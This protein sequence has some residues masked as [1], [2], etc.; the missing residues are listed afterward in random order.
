MEE[1]EEEKEEEEDAEVIASRYGNGNRNP[2]NTYCLI[3]RCWI[4]LS[5]EG[6][7][8]ITTPS[9][10]GEEGSAAE[11]KAKKQ[12]R[13]VM[14]RVLMSVRKSTLSRTYIWCVKKHKPGE[15]KWHI[16][17]YSLHTAHTTNPQYLQYLPAYLPTLWYPMI[18]YDTHLNSHR[19][20]VCQVHAYLQ[21][22]HR[23][24]TTGQHS[25]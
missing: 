15:P 19:Q 7:S 17:I 10:A 2:G 21:Y 22:A 8:I 13:R 1:G 6:S 25:G 23:A 24:H 16:G 3:G 5:R 12:R 9:Q 18:S 4:N 14:T 20:R 11:N